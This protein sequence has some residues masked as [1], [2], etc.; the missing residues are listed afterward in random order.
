MLLEG[1]GLGRV[2]WGEGD[3]WM[4]EFLADREN[5]RMFHS[6]TCEFAWRACV[7]VVLCATQWCVLCIPWCVVVIFDT[8][9]CWHVERL[10]NV[11]DQHNL[12]GVVTVTIANQCA[13]GC[14]Q[15]GRCVNASPINYMSNQVDLTFT[16]SSLR[17]DRHLFVQQQ[18]SLV[19]DIRS[20]KK[21]IQCYHVIWVTTAVWT[22]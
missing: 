15:L 17:H 16:S 4:L 2:S 5:I 14:V 12:S 18:Y 11:T 1:R 6:K 10:P 20:L 3:V 7:V 19:D 22:R 8:R 9:C 21:E 13:I